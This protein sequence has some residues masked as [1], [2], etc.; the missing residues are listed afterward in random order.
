MRYK[1]SFTREKNSTNTIPLHHQKLI[2]DA[3]GP[4]IDSISNN[5]YDF[6][7]SSLKATTKIQNG[8]MKLLSAKITLVISGR[9]D[10][11]VTQLKDKIFE[12]SKMIIGRLTLRPKRHELIPEPV[13][14]TRMR[15]LC[16]SPL[17]L[18]NPNT[19][20]EKALQT[21]D[22]ASHEFSDLLYNSVLDK[23]EK[24]GYTEEQLTRYAEFEVIPDNEYINK[25]RHEGKKFVRQYKCSSGLPMMGYLLPFTLHAHEDVHRFI[26]QTGIGVL[27]DEGYGMLDVVK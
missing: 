26:W 23:M 20:A 8:Y 2:N 19:E 3:L 13:F 1:I 4:M 17:V 12:Q 25:I 6:N 7:F 22:P 9:K 14:Q 18:S 27:T 5:R 24:A 11:E 10:E 21:V 15:Y 16:I